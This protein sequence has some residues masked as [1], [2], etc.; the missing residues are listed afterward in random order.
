MI[1]YKV[2]HINIYFII[3]KNESSICEMETFRKFIALTSLN[4]VNES[5]MQ[6]RY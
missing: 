5:L 3:R 1:K 6:L 4:T 2:L